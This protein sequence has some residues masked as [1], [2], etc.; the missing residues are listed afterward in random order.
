MKF[1]LKEQTEN[2]VG[3]PPKMPTKAE[4]L[5]IVK[6]MHGQELARAISRAEESGDFYR[7]DKRQQRAFLL[8][9]VNNFYKENVLDNVHHW[10]DITHNIDDNQQ[11]IY[12][13]LDIRDND[14][15]AYRQQ[16]G[17]VYRTSEL[18]DWYCSTHKG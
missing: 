16:F 6:R 12:I 9:L 14:F 17:G 13:V 10:L 15:D 8:E 4:L 18:V 7:E 3:V 5:N 2:I 1:T 11:I